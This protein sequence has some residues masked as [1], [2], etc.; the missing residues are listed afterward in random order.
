MIFLKRT[1]PVLLCFLA[2]VIFLAQFFVPTRE[3][4]IAL[5]HGSNTVKVVI[6][7]SY[8]IGLYSLSHLHWSRIARR[9]PG[10]GYSALVF[11]GLIP[12]IVFG[13]SGEAQKFANLVLGWNTQF[14][15]F[16]EYAPDG[17]GVVHE[18]LFNYVLAAAQST[19]FSMLAFFI[20]SA[21]Y[22]TFR[23]RTVESA[24]LLIA[25]AL[26]IF[27]RVPLSGVISEW[28]PWAADQIMG[29]PNLAAKRG[30]MI[31]VSLGMVG[32][33]LRVI[34]GIERAYIGGD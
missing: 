20:A 21:A 15:G 11:V 31:G 6:G 13:L 9:Q 33:A 23:A 8:L 29:Y 26:V 14:A 5:Q 34:F 16:Q 22:R 27:G 19:M 25:A 24:F 32:T 1:L 17:K 3:S 10:W 18:W 2:G 12:M 4:A 28:F 7:F 30:I